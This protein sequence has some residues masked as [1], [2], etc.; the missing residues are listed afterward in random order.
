[1]LV[2]SIIIQLTM[3]LL[4]AS[5]ALWI[6]ELFNGA[7][8]SF[9][10]TTPIHK[11]IA[12]ASGLLTVPWFAIG[13]IAVRKERKLLMVAFFVLTSL[14]L[15]SWCG[16]F[17]S[18]TFGVL[19]GKWPFFAALSVSAFGL[20]VVSLLVSVLCRLH[21]GQGLATQLAEQEKAEDEKVPWEFSNAAERGSWQSFET[22]EIDLKG[23]EDIPRYMGPARAF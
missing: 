10:S 8:S 20:L 21:F 11:G 2:L 7:I 19:F 18:Q 14:F 15:V 12:L 17:A 1:M 16:T 5:L 6:D 3:F 9:S 4:I 22:T 13:W 23:A